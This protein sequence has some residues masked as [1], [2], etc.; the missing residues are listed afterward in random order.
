MMESEGFSDEDIFKA[1]ISCGIDE[2]TTEEEVQKKM[3]DC[4]PEKLEEIGNGKD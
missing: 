1:M 3:I 2:E 4:V